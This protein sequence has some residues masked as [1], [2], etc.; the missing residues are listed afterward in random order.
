MAVRGW[1][2]SGVPQ[3]GQD[4]REDFWRAGR[5]WE[6]WERSENPSQR[7]RSGWEALLKGWRRPEVPPRWP[8]GFGRPSRRVGRSF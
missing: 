3:V 2:G 8:G 7:A 4:K 5:D 1:E 6:G